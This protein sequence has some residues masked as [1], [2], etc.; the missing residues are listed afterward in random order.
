MFNLSNLRGLL[1]QVL[2]LPDLHTVVLFTPE[3]QLVSYASDP[4]K[5]KEHVRVVVGLSAEI[6]QETKEQGI[7][8]VDSEVSSM[9][10]YLEEFELTVLTQLGR[11]IVLSIPLKQDEGETLDGETLNAEALDVD[12]EVD[13]MMLLALNADSS[14][15]WKELEHKV[16]TRGFFVL[17]YLLELAN[18]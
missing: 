3:G 4:Y 12:D 13:P 7:G 16:W 10:W 5:S 15:T 2:S 9:L 1:V 14:V 17:D 18:L 8:M 11:L 6:W